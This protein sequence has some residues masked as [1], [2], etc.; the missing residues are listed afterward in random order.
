MEEEVPRKC[1]VL[2]YPY[3]PVT[4][5][6]LIA[7]VAKRSYAVCRNPDIEALT[8]WHGGY[9]PYKQCHESCCSLTSPELYQSNFDRKL[10]LSIL[11]A[12]PLLHLEG[13]AMLWSTNKF[14]FSNP[15]VFTDFMKCVGSA[16]SIRKLELSDELVEGASRQ[17]Q[18]W[19]RII[20]QDEALLDWGLQGRK[21][22]LL[23]ALKSVEHLEV[24][25][26]HVDHVA[27][28]TNGMEPPKY[29]E[30]LRTELCAAFGDLRALEYVRTINTYA[31]MQIRPV[32]CNCA[33]PQMFVFDVDDE[34]MRHVHTYRIPRVEESFNR[35]I[36]SPLR[37]ALIGNEEDFREQRRQI[38]R[39]RIEASERQACLNCEHEHLERLNRRERR[40]RRQLF[41]HREGNRDRSLTA[42]RRAHDAVSYK[43]EL[44]Y[45]LAEEEL[46]QKTSEYEKESMAIAL[47]SADA[48]KRL[49]ELEERWGK[50][51]SEGL[52]IEIFGEDGDSETSSDSD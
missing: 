46:N 25:F 36:E 39:L 5:V 43:F 37:H 15:H 42:R 4:L 9:V 1:N 26:H 35:E 10:H 28:A 11:R 18:T 31:S 32:P 3:L 49:K 20:Q 45:S 22:R 29:D 40:A 24:Y 8:K 2:N 51:A 23:D 33:G 41:A 7:Q 52:N 14:A 16:Q 27:K 13:S 21:P 19:N 48:E 38:F 6:N 44:A 47:L 17:D 30:G 34:A 50:M 12:S